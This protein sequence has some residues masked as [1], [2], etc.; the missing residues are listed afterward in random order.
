VT[1]IAAQMEGVATFMFGTRK[2]PADIDRVFELMLA[3]AIRIA[4]GRIDGQDAA[5]RRL[6]ADWEL[7]L[8]GFQLDAGAG[9]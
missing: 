4:L 5:E 6:V 2:Q 9:V 8:E 7:T 3:R 1:V